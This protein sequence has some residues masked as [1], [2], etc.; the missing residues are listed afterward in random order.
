MICPH[1]KGRNFAWSRRCE[2]CARPLDASEPTDPAQPAVLPELTL[3]IPESP[4]VQE[5]E[6][7]KAAIR[8]ALA[9]RGTR[10][11]LTPILMAANVVM[12]VLMA[13]EERQV[14]SFA[15][16]T[17]LEWGG[18][19]SPDVTQGAWW[20]LI[21][22]VFLHGGLLHISANMFALAI[23]GPVTERL[24]GALGCRLGGSR[25]RLCFLGRGFLGGGGPSR[26][27]GRRGFGRRSCRRRG[28][29]LGLRA[30]G[31]WRCWGWLAGR[32]RWC[33]RRRCGSLTFLLRQLERSRTQR[34]AKRS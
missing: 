3:A 9:E 25:R 4:E 24:Y 31:C 11:V 6:A 7:R 21:T 33:G 22:A 18:S 23:I 10:V 28:G 19:Y 27:G 5:R 34:V 1:C 30:N 8:T 2:H 14:G 15:A 29:A 12:F 32:G 16:D 26:G 20:R 13:I 17:L